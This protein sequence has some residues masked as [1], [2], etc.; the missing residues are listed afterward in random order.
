MVSEGCYVRRFA[1]I[2]Q[3]GLV[4]GDA[5]RFLWKIAATAIAKSETVTYATNKTSSRRQLLQSLKLRGFDI[6]SLCIKSG[7]ISGGVAG[8]LTERQG[9]QD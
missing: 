6:E 2:Y 7:G 8:L 9:Q 5:T 3:A 4:D 1:E